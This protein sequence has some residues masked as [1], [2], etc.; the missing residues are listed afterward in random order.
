MKWS[1]EPQVRYINHCIT[2]LTNIFNKLNIP[3][4]NISEFFYVFLS[5]ENVFQKG[6]L[7]KDQ[8]YL[9]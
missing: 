1:R 6:S 8:I 3:C 9:I 5:K 2:A 4:L 7:L